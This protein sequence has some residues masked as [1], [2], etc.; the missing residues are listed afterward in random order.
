MK[1]AFF[2]CSLL[3][4]LSLTTMPARAQ[5]YSGTWS[6]SPADKAGS[7]HLRLEYRRTGLMGNEEWDE[8]D[9]VPASELHRAGNG[10]TLVH[11]AG[12]FAATGVFSGSAGGG[13]WTFVPDPRF[14]SALQQRGVDAPSDKQ[15][16][17]LAMGDFKIA[18]LDTLLH[19]GFE[20]PSAGDLV[21]MTEHGVTADY[22]AA[23][24]GLNFQPKTVGWLIALRDHGVTSGYLQALASAG[25]AN[26]NAPDAQRLVDHG[27][28]REYLDGLRRLG[29]HPS[30]D[31]LVR[32]A[33]HGVSIAFIERM[34]SHGYTH[35]SV[36]DLIKLR[37]HGF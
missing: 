24:K 15:Q 20:R 29:Y 4:V 23:M 36:D 33:D 16:F 25:Y 27:V 22:V 18:T 2:L 8:E 34:R 21:A 31:D 17:Q 9:D 26:I 3:L 37:D 12:R 28:S 13:T 30:A 32:L 10:F 14:A 7:V 6:M 5:T 19:S 1:R 11:D 35:L